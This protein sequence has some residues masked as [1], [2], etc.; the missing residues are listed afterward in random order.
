MRFDRVISVHLRETGQLN[1]TARGRLC[2]LELKLT[3]EIN[4]KKNV[5]VLRTIISEIQSILTEV[6]DLISEKFAIEI[7]KI[8]LESLNLENEISS[9]EKL[10]HLLVKIDEWPVDS[11]V[12]EPFIA[13]IES[14]LTKKELVENSH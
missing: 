12:K 3:V 4:N 11:I 9:Q 6:S 8:Q 10:N 7:A 2:L 1:L 5:D 14:L 13:M